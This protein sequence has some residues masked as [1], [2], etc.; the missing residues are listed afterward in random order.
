MSADIRTLTKPELLSET[1]LIEI[2]RSRCI[3]L[4]NI[5][6]LKRS[7][8]VEMYRRI[9][10]PLPQRRYNESK[11]LGKKLNDLRLTRKIAVAI[12]EEQALYASF[13]CSQN[14]TSI[15]TNSDRCRSSDE[16]S[17]PLPKKA[18]L[19]NSNT[20]TNGSPENGSSTTTS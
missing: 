14:N 13:I 1:D 9:A 4:P 5:K 10:L 8:L 12:E 3:E 19:S 11:Y 17:N 2:L 15:K 16:D 6:M 20:G 18:R 7:D